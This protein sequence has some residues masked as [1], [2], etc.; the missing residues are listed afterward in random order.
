VAALL[1]SLRV[2]S[3]G[4]LKLKTERNSRGST[5]IF[6]VTL[7]NRYREVLWVGM[8]ET[9]SSRKC[10]MESTV[11]PMPAVCQEICQTLLKLSHTILTLSLGC[12]A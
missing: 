4:D 6:K 12:G 2:C 5:Y 1:L 11:H 7:P 9:A 3:R 8:A 10:A